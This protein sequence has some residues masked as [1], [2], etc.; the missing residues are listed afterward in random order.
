MGGGT[1]GS[2]RVGGRAS[3]PVAAAPGRVSVA[4]AAVR[5]VSPAVGGGAGPDEPHGRRGE[6]QKILTKAAKRRRRTNILTAA[7]AVVV[8]LLGVGVVGGTWFFDDVE[9]PAQREEAQTNVILDSK[10]AVLA[11]LGDQN[12]T[13]VPQAKISEVVKHAVV[14]A[15]DK[16]FYRHDGIDFKGIARAAWNNFVS[17]DLQ[18]ASTITQQYARYAADLKGINVNRKLREAVIARKLEDRYEKDDILGMYLNYIYLGEGRYGIEAAAQ[19]YFGKSVMTPPGSKN[20][21]TPYEAAVLA[22]IIK[23][24]NPDPATGHK[25]YNPNVNP[26]AAKGRWDYTLQNMLEEK[27]ITPEVY[28]ARKYPK[29]KPTSSNKCKT[30]ADGKPVGMIMRHVNAELR[31]MG[32]SD[33]EFERGG[34]TVTTTIDPE[35]QKAAEE[36]GSRN[37]E[38][39][40]MNGRPKTYQAAVIGIDPKTGRVLG[41]FG[42]EDPNG[43]DYGSYLNG[44]GTGFS[45]R[46]Q[47][48]GSTMKIYTLAAALR[49]NIS[50]KTTWDGTKKR[51]NGTKISNAGRTPGAICRGKI[52]F[53]DLETATIESYNFPFYWIADG[54]G[55]EKVIEAARDAGLEHLWPD[56]GPV[57]DL[58]NTNAST[59]KKKGYFDNEVAFGQYHVSPLE[60]AQGVSTIVNRGARNDA[61]FIKKVEAVDQVTGKKKIVAAEKSKP[62]QVFTQEHMADLEGVLA[63]IPG[64]SGNNL[65]NGRQS[66]A[67]SGTWEFDGGSGDCWFVGG[68]PQLSATVWVGGSGNKVKLKEP[69]GGDMFGSGTPAQIWEDFINAVTKVKEME[70]EQFPPRVPTG[71][72]KSPFA[73]GK[74]PPPPPVTQPGTN[75]GQG[76]NPACEFLPDLCPNNGGGNNGGGNNG[77]GNNG[78][79][80]DGG[81]T[82]GQNNGGIVTFPGGT[83]NDTGTGGGQV[84]GDRADG[85][86]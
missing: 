41:Y 43:T 14:A 84:D 70:Q 51:A 54:I 5:P 50:F 85:G 57:V 59:W 29:V 39:S 72:D 65:R 28:A 60:H 12:R 78:G 68:I 16:N 53:C 83:G 19:G 81:G 67:K 2:A 3:A 56:E 32:I 31:E 76:Q 49:E 73:N 86:G 18:G 64:Q 74:Q 44:D 15:E 27:W 1:V 37:K 30:C 13:V 10:G 66:I 35:V 38:S 77:G 69:N 71:D 4:R 46:G 61:H 7:A 26:E 63:K 9:L 80:N 79:Q 34:L 47:S 52:E 48:P 20:A 58:N 75:P 82:N 33:A 55:R 42:G 62:K 21:I 24:P 8:I 45:G 36:A 22:S 25:G 40:P 6:A 11:K 17:D 23:Q